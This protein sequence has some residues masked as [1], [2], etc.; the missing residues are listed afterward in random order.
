MVAVTR[1]ERAKRH[2]WPT[3]KALLINEVLDER[4]EL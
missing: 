1:K 4:H 3:F 2:E